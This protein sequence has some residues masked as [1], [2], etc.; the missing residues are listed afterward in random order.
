MNAAIIFPSDQISCN[1]SH[2]NCVGA[3][4]VVSSPDYEPRGTG[5]TTRRSQDDRARVAGQGH[6]VLVRLGGDRR[7][8]KIV[9][10]RVSG[11]RV[12]C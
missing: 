1:T 5:L 2:F 7:V 3:V 8:K 11:V 10:E 6:V 4:S 12:I 9:R